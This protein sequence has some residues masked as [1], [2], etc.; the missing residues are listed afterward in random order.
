MTD[1]QLIFYCQFL[2]DIGDAEGAFCS[3][4]GD[5]DEE[6]PEQKLKTNDC[7]NCNDCIRRTLKE[8]RCNLKKLRALEV[9]ATYE[10]KE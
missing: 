2:E 6:H 9:V 3:C 1:E 5:D 10:M 8:I 4:C 7:E